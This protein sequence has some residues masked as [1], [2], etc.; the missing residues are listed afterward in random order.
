MHKICGVKAKENL[1]VEAVFFDGT[2]KEY[3]IKEL[4]GK[5]PQLRRLENRELFCG[6]AVDTGGYGI[7]WDDELDLEA[8]TIWEEGVTVRTVVTGLMEQLAARL[9]EA[10]E[11]A[12]ITQKEL[13]ER[14]NIYQTDISKLERG[15][16]NP[17]VATLQRL[18]EGLG[19][20]LCITFTSRT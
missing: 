20:T 4:F 12:G 2:V 1:I 17:S 16:G 8:E 6:V 10:R 5:Y 18:A 15:I 13:S 3:D 14:T 9:I 11:S 19:M 7:S